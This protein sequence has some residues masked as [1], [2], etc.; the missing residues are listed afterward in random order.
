MFNGI[1]VLDRVATL[2]GNL[3]KHEKTW[4]LIIQAKTP[5]KTWNLRNFEKKP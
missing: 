5:G 4:N 1:N 2:P 3:E